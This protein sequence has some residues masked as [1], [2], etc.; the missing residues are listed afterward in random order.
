[1]I[2][3]DVPHLLDLW[4]FTDERKAWLSTVFILTSVWV[5]SPSIQVEADNQVS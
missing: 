3:M 4:R 1:M 5:L 2:R